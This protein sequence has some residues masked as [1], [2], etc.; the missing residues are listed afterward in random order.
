MIKQIWQLF[1][2]VHTA[3]HQQQRYQW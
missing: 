1:L 2:Q 3:Q